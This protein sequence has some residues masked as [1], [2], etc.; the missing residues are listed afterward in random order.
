MAYEQNEHSEQ[1]REEVADRVNSYRTKRSR[2]RLSG[3]FSMRFDFEESGRAVR[4]AAADLEPSHD[5]FEGPAI[6]T[7]AGIPQI[8]EATAT[9]PVPAPNRTSLAPA[10]AHVAVPD[11]AAEEPEPAIIAGV[12]AQTRTEGAEVLDPDA[13]VPSY[14]N[15]E[16]GPAEALR[17]SA[18]GTLIEFPRLSFMESTNDFADPVLDSPRILDV[19]ESSVEPVETGPLADIH[20]DEGEQPVERKE[21]EI[22]LQVAPTI[23][24]IF[25]GS[26][27]CLL[28]AIASAAFMAIVTRLAGQLPRTKPAM[29]IVAVV[30]CLLWAIYQYLFLVYG[31]V[32]AGMRMARLQL[33]TFQKETPRRA[34]RRAR[35]LTM[36]ISCASLGLGF[37]WAFADEDSLCWHDRISRTYLSP[38]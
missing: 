18:K 3:E 28:V 29:A 26:V 2:T 38:L 13:E 7:S 15:H 36:L 5:R 8:D 27:D 6:P 11:I 37:V 19:P 22:P 31:G 25:A 17:P 24:R 35:A 33:Y 23:R 21:F 14:L 34:T 16:Q 12:L 1:W 4:S 30:P 9:S 32:T 10:A 20:L